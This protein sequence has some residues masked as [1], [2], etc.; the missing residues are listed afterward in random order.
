M[1]KFFCILALLAGAV[2]SFAQTAEEIISRMDEAME[3]LGDV[4]DGVEMVVELKM[5]ILGTISTKTASLGDKI[6]MKANMMG[7]EIITW[8]DGKTK[9]TY[10]SD[11]NEIEIEREDPDKPT[12]SDGDAEMLSGITEG[13]RVSIKKETAQAWYIL[14]RKSPDNKDK[15]APKTMDLAVSKGNYM[16][17]SL[18]AKMSDVTVTMRDFVF[19][20][21]EEQV[22]FNPAA[23]PNAKIID[24]R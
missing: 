14:C 6:C 11:S 12:E 5:P 16:P 13:Y 10:T 9:W 8:S 21:T 7:E 23:Y 18:S 20:V 3:R 2:P 17:M 15:D 22:T 24:K 19:G 4:D 1:K